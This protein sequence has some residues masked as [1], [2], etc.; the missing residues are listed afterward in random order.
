MIKYAI[1]KFKINIKLCLEIT[2]KKV[3]ILQNPKKTINFDY[4]IIYYIV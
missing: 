1:S 3:M 2:Q 4:E